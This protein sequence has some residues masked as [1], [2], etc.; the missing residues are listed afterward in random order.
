MWTERLDKVIAV[1]WVGVGSLL[2]R[3]PAQFSRYFHGDG[4]FEVLS[5]FLP[6]QFREICHELVT[7][8]DSGHAWER[9]SVCRRV[10]KGLSDQRL[11]TD[12]Q[13]LLCKTPKNSF[14]KILKYCWYWTAACYICGTTIRSAWHWY[15]L[16]RL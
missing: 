2:Y 10:E 1:G 15:A 8:R 4:S 6:V 7:L 16:S 9:K 14:Q 3:W 13:L 12:V 11:P 5:S